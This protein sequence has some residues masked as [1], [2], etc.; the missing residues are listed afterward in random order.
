MKEYWMLQVSKLLD[1][2]FSCNDR[3]KP[4]L[5]VAYVL[6]EIPW[7]KTIVD[8]LSA[9]RDQMESFSRQL[10]PARHK[11]FAHQDLEVHTK[12][13][14]KWF[15]GFSIKDDERFYQNLLEFLNLVQAELFGSPELEWPHLE[16][17]HFA[18]TDAQEFMEVLEKGGYA[19]A[20]D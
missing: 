2:K 13:G 9:L 11:I 18:E 1:K 6:E 15:G 10:E 17:P 4:N 20:D 19:V 5:V 16:W 8:R 12:H 3:S 14:N 7:P